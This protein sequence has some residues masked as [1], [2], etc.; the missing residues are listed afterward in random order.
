MSYLS[1]ENNI[2]EAF[3]NLILKS[4]NGVIDCSGATISNVTIEGTIKG[5]DEIKVTVHMPF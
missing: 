3:R 1:F 5:S 2:I 4:T